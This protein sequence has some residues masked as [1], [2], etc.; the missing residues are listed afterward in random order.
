MAFTLREGVRETPGESLGEKERG[1][2][3]WGGPVGARSGSGRER[4]G[5]TSESRLRARRVIGSEGIAGGAEGAVGQR[6]P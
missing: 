4:V 3:G 2:V 1:R 6:V 5:V